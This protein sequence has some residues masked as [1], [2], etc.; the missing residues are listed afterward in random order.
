MPTAERLL[1]DREARPPLGRKQSAGRSKQ[2]TVNGRVLRPPPAAP[3]DRNLVAQNHDLELALTAAAGE[4][5]EE[6]AQEPVQHAGQQKHPVCTAPAM[7]VGTTGTAESSFFTPHA[8]PPAPSPDHQHRILRFL[9]PLGFGVGERRVADRRSPL[10]GVQGAGDC[11]SATSGIRAAP[12]GHPPT[13]RTERPAAAGGGEPAAAPLP[14]ELIPRDSNYLASLA[15]AAGRR[16]LDEFRQSRSAAKSVVSSAS[17]S[18]SSRVRTHAGA[19]SG[20]SA[21]STGWAYPSRLRRC[22]RS[23]TRQASVL[24]AGVRPCRGGRS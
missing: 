9:A 24:P 17:S 11:R 1:A 20:S 2:R 3:Q 12:S 22:G 18:S 6:T 10:R 13:A 23:C 8:S 16:P 5:T 14:P 21:R 19:T 7:I 4:Q 15:S